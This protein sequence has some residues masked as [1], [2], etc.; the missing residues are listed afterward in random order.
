MKSVTRDPEWRGIMRIFLRGLIFARITYVHTYTNVDGR[1]AERILTEMMCRGDASSRRV[2]RSISRHNVKP[3]RARRENNTVVESSFKPCSRH[4]VH[5]SEITRLNCNYIGM[6]ISR[7][8]GPASARNY[9]TVQFR[10]LDLYFRWRRD[11]YRIVTT[12][13]SE[14]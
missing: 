12:A 10:D 1:S 11:M 3:T 14:A 7:R 9:P 2:S 4:G 6:Q 8:G 5:V 13:I